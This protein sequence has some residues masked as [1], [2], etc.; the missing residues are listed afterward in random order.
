MTEIDKII[1]EAKR[2]LFIILNHQPKMHL[3]GSERDILQALGNDK[4]V[5][6][7]VEENHGFIRS[8]RGL[9]ASVDERS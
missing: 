8:D 2:R 5:M 1:R 4:D 9:V 6:D 7:L 3:R